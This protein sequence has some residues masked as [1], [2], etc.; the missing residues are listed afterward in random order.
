MDSTGASER[1]QNNNLKVMLSYINYLGKS[2]YLSKIKT[3][4][5]ILSFLETKKKSKDEDPDQKWI[6]TWNHYLHRIKRFF[7]WYYNCGFKLLEANEK[8]NEIEQKFYE[9][10]SQENWKILIFLKI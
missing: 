9:N 5:S 4:Q 6:T 8:E 1:H 2:D 3:C 10:E 7:R